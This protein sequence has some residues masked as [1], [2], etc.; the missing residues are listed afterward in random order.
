MLIVCQSRL[1]SFSHHQSLSNNILLWSFK[2][3]TQKIPKKGKRK[4]LQSLCHDLSWPI[5]CLQ[6]GWDS[7]FKMAHY[8]TSLDGNI[9][10]WCLP[11]GKPRGHQVD[12]KLPSAHQ[13][14][15]ATSTSVPLDCVYLSALQ[16]N[17]SH[18]PHTFQCIETMP[19]SHC[20]VRTV[21]RWECTL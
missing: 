21:Y 8:L 9:C 12:R 7:N 6:G 20:C 13:T 16:K 15:S 2:V 14:W 1:S 3:P 10:L 18:A 11:S 19:T 5:S 4:T 17:M